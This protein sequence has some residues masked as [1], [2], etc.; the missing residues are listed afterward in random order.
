MTYGQVKSRRTYFDMG[1]TKS[2]CY[3]LNLLTKSWLCHNFVKNLI[4]LM[5]SVFVVGDVYIGDQEIIS[6]IQDSGNMGVGRELTLLSVSS[7]SSMDFVES[8][9]EHENAEWSHGEVQ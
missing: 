5:S 3:H 2:L 8:L 6:I 9:G 4:P 1:L 7:K